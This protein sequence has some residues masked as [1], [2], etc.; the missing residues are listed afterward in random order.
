MSETFRLDF[1]YIYTYIIYNIQCMTLPL[2]LRSPPI[3]VPSDLDL[4]AHFALRLDGIGLLQVL[5]NF[6]HRLDNLA[7]RAKASWH[8]FMVIFDFVGFHV[9]FT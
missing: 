9:E 8:D 4:H 6:D 3:P 5:G 7:R 1:D 2:A